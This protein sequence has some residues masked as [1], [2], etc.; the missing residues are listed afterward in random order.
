MLA[1]IALPAAAPALAQPVPG[2]GGPGGPGGP[3]RELRHEEREARKDYRRDVREVR[4]DQREARRDDRRDDRRDGPRGN[5]R[6]DYR[7]FDYNRPDPRYGN[8]RADRYYTQGNNNGRRLGV[9][10]RIYRGGDNRYYCR[11]NDGTTGLIV[12]ALG[13]GVLGN[14]IAPGGSKTLGT[15]LGGGGGA[16]LGRSVDR[17]NVSCR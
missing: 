15:I 10:D 5:D 3:D 17:N 8:Y 11:R 13:G 1:A 16:L 2:P 9:N 7:G 6:R 4:Q 14:V 12:G